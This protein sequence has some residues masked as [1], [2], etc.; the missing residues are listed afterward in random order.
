MKS[1][2][3]D[4]EGRCGYSRHGQSSNS[5]YVR[6]HL[7]SAV[8]SN[9]NDICD[10]WVIRQDVG[11]ATHHQQL[12][13][14]SSFQ[15]AMHLIDQP[16]QDEEVLATKKACDNGDEGQ[17]ANKDPKTTSSQPGAFW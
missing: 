7:L 1:R 14:S 2:T 9:F 16:L 3:L 17:P 4:P 10:I 6:L 11:E 15:V 13:V 12:H 5:I 8:L